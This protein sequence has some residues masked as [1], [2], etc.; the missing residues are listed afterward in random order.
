MLREETKR[1][2]NSDVSSLQELWHRT[3]AEINP[4]DIYCDVKP[5]L[6]DEESIA[7]LKDTL[8][9]LRRVSDLLTD[10]LNAIDKD[11]AICED[12]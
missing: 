6:I 5:E 2:F 3:D 1:Q 12:E 11:L 7:D 4:F 10:V 8:I 9:Q